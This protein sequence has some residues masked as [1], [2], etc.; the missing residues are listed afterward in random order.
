M[1]TIAFTLVFSFCAVV[2]VHSQTV[3]ELDNTAQGW[4]GGICCISGVNYNF[5]M[6]FSG[7]KN[8]PIPDTIWVGGEDIPLVITDSAL[9][10]MTANSRRSR[11]GKTIKFQFAVGVSHDEKSNEFPG[12]EEHKPKPAPIQ[13]TGVAL[14]SYHEK[15][16]SKRQYYVVKKVK[17]LEYQNYP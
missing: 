17:E 1:K 14:V 2:M 10:G 6:E 12:Y 9:D 4:S 5:N 16:S 3:K 7:Y 8:E 15:G 11:I 13:F